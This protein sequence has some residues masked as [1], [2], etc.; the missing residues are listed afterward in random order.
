MLCLQ[1]VS[2][3]NRFKAAVY[4]VFTQ[5]SVEEVHIPLVNMVIAAASCGIPP[6]VGCIHHFCQISG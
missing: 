1:L 5:I 6:E 3:G 2:T 4:Y